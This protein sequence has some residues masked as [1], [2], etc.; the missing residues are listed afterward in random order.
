MF[1]I[2]ALIFSWLVWFAAAD[3]KRWKEILP[4]FIF[5]SWLSFIV[6][7]WMHNVYELWS[8]SGLKIYPLFAN[9][10]GIYI[11]VPYFF[12]IASPGKNVKKNGCLLL[13]MG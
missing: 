11:V 8:Y 12:T 7:A 13:S 4:V 2:V 1:W 5:A 10:L 9:A 3:K 6:E